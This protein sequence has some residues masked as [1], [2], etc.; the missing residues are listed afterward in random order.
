MTFKEF[1][2]LCEFA[3]NLNVPL[4]SVIPSSIPFG[5]ISGEDERFSQD[6]TTTPPRRADHQAL[7]LPSVTITSPI[8]HIAGPGMQQIGEPEQ[9]GRK[10]LVQITLE[11]G[12]HLVL[13]WNEFK[14]IHGEP[15]KNKMM[16]VVFQR[17]PDDSSPIPSKVLSA[18][19]H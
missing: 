10:N 5:A 9:N 16:T 2:R 1:F 13:T 14:R 7:G 6:P 17:R 8:K 12:T 4:G 15:R 11:D 18:I 19:V 3:T